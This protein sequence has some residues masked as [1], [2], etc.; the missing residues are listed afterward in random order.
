MI[1][2]LQR[3]S[4]LDRHNEYSKNARAL[5]LPSSLTYF[6][7]F[8]SPLNFLNNGVK[9]IALMLELQEAYLKGIQMGLIW[10][11]NIFYFKGQQF[12]A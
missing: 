11:L 9:K 5:K 6:I 1:A 7:I 10:H 4:P 3:K 8:I 2:Y 12:T